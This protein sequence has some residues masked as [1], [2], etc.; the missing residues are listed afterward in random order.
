MDRRALAVA[1]ALVLA[2]CSVPGGATT[3]PATGPETT[4]ELETVTNES[5]TAAART[6]A[7]DAL[8]DGLYGD[9]S[10]TD[11]AVPYTGDGSERVETT[12]FAN[13]DSGIYVRVVVPVAYEYDCGDRSGSAQVRAV[14]VYRVT[15]EG[16]LDPVTEPPDPV[17]GEGGLP[18]VVRRHARAVFAVAPQP[19]P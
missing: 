12:L 9:A 18:S 14:A 5:A 17:C 4:I 10:Y 8:A 3:T 16:R 6:A 11:V 1:A 13:N 7:V 15:P 19:R 2:G